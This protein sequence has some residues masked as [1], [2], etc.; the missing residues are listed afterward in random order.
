MN[1]VNLPQESQDNSNLPILRHIS[2]EVERSIQHVRD[3]MTGKRN[4][5]PTKWKRLN[6]NLM[7]GLQPGKMYVIA[8]RP[9]VGKSAFSNQLIF[10]LLDE[11]AQKDMMVVYW[12][13][14]MPGDQQILRAGSKDTKLQTFE[15]LSV[16]QKLSEEKY[17]LYVNETQKYKNYPIYFCSIPQDMNAVKKVNERIFNKHPQRTVINLIDHSRLVLG[18]EET[19]LQNLNVL[20]KGCMWMQARMGSITILLSQLNRNIEQ[21]HRAKN[22]YQPLLT[23]LFGGDSIG[24]DAHVVMMLQRPYDLYGITDA[25]CGEDPIGL[26]AVHIEKNRDGLLGMIPFQTDLSTFTIHERAIKS[27]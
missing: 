6:K 2:K 21:E 4:V 7:G 16:E 26:L 15:L 27:T 12:S 14:E 23:D 22:Q 18:R 19:E 17:K 20:S 5:L 13:F 11:N 24:Q 25:Y 1:Q 10:D 3:G 8:G 9:G